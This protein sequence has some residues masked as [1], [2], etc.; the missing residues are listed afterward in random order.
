MEMDTDLEKGLRALPT[1][2][3]IRFSIKARD[4]DENT[5]VHTAFKE[6]C[7]MECDDNYTIGLRKLLEFYEQHAILDLIS[8][9]IQELELRVQRLEAPNKE[10]KKDESEMF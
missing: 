10:V 6:F 8:N 2:G 4:T 7:K 5:Q 3:F 1:E 9:R